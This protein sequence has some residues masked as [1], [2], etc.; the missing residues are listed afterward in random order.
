MMSNFSPL[1]QLQLSISKNRTVQ[2]VP[3]FVGG[4]HICLTFISK[5][6]TQNVHQSAWS[7]GPVK[8]KVELK[9]ISITPGVQCVITAGVGLMQR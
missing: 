2:L 4:H 8:L 5:F 7:V 9:S 1:C 6:M 3:S